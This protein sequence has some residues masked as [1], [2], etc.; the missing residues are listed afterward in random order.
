MPRDL[1]AEGRHRV[2]VAG[3]SVVRAVAAYYGA[4]PNGAP[5]GDIE[6][7]AVGADF[8]CARRADGSVLCWGRSDRLGNGGTGSTAQ[9]FATEVSDVDD[10]IEIA[11]GANHACVRRR[12]GQ[13]QC[14]GDNAYGRLGVNPVLTSA[15]EPVNVLGLP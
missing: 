14:W 13:V 2:E 1:R 8:A 6:Q 3:H 15:A 5:I 4:Q 9:R 12:S 10:A 11:A 7:V